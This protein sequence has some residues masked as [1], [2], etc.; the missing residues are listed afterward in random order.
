M[1]VL[2]LTDIPPCNNFTAGIVLNKLVRFLPAGSLVMCALVDKSITP[3]MPND[4]IHIPSLIMNKPRETAL[5]LFSGFIGTA[6]DYIYEIIQSVRTTIFLLPKIIKFAKNQNIEAI[7]IVLQGQTM[8]RLAL[9]LS[10]KLGV[11]MYTQV[12]DPF[13]WWLRAN[14]IDRFTQRRL[15]VEYDNVIEN[16]KGCATASWA[17]SEIYT[18]KYGVRNLPVIAGLPH[19]MLRKPS[20]KR[21]S[22]KQFIIGFAGQLYAKNELSSLFEALNLTD[23]E[24]AGYPIFIR[25][26][27]GE[28]NIKSQNPVNIEY[29]GWQS[30]EDTIRLLAESDLL[31]LPY[32]FSEEFREESTLSFPSKLISYFA[33]GRPVF[34]HAP[35]Y[36]SPS[37]YIE[38]NNA[39]YL[40]NTLNPG[41][42][43]KILENVIK[44]ELAYKKIIKNGTR[45]FLKDFTENKMK[46]S[47][48]HFLEL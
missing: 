45:C 23:W 48:L 6:I 28:L 27:G 8:I 39:G 41:K 24:V 18:K 25:I 1:K 19:K 44:D 3:K 46:E 42:I 22:K 7:W 32:W 16:S 35:T 34:C 30:E 20:L 11:H 12:W 17:M 2:L 10:K 37:R 40:C 38:K 36:A 31:Y 15:L 5:G 29:L 47:F 13:S 21:K 33:S 43:L 14:K 26:M 4:L 9:P